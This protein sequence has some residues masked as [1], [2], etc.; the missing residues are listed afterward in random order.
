[1][2]G[3]TAGHAPYIE[4]TNETFTM[5][6]TLAI[7]TMTATPAHGSDG[8]VPLDPT[9]TW[10]RLHQLVG[11]GQTDQ[12][13]ELVS[14]I[15]P[16]LV[17]LDSPVEPIDL[18]RVFQAAGEAAMV[19]GDRVLAESMWQ[20]AVRIDSG[21][22]LHSPMVKSHL[23]DYDAQRALIEQ[24][25][26]AVVRGAGDIMV[27]GAPVACGDTLPV[28][29]GHHVVQWLAS[30]DSLISR[31]V[32]VYG[33]QPV[34]LGPDEALSC[35]D[36][37]EAAPTP[38]RPRWGWMATGGGLLLVGGGLAAWGWWGPLGDY[39]DTRETSANT[40]ATA[41]LTGGAALMVLGGASMGHSLHT[42]KERTFILPLAQG[43][44]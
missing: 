13:L 18:V 11:E 16:S 1:M 35:L 44:W 27:D 8:C 39:V 30:D 33:T 43:R 28:H 14:T 23:V 36:I 32:E 22:A 38:R 26:M 17:C 12:A 24:A 5:F 20:R 21:A 41:A 42:D 4:S 25:P 7:I 2:G 34:L 10:N 9:T 37:T 15:E 40:A 19:G 3:A 31:W 6:Y 29:A